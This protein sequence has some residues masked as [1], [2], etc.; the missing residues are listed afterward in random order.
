MVSWAWNS[1]LF[2]AVL[3]AVTWELKQSPGHTQDIIKVILKTDFKEI[4]TSLRMEVIKKEF[5][6][7]KTQEKEK[8]IYIKA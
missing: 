8:E 5:S 1:N 6:E 2:A 7:I 3:E 4:E